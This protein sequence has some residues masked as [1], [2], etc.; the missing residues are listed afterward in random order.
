MKLNRTVL[1][2]ASLVSLTAWS[3]C[4]LPAYSQGNDF[5]KFLQNFSGT[6]TGWSDFDNRRTQID[7][8]IKTNLTNKKINA[9]QAT[10]LQTD[11][12]KI[13]QAA[14][15]IRLN[16]KNPSFT[17][18]LALT[19][20]LNNLYARLQQSVTEAQ[21][22]LP[23][24]TLLRKQLQERLAG[25][26]S[27]GNLSQ[28]DAE[29]VNHDLKHAADIE[30]AFLAAGEGQL[31]P[32]QTQIL[33][34]DLEKTK[35]KLEQQIRLSQSAVPE[36]NSRRTAIEKKILDSTA[37]GKVSVQQ[38][39]ELRAE[40]AR[41]NSMQTTFLSSEGALS[42]S[43]VLALAGDLDKLNERIDVLCRL[44]TTTTTTTTTPSTP[45]T[46]TPST[47]TP[48][49]T[50]PSAT[51]PLLVSATA[52][53]DSKVILL[54]HRIQDNHA[55]GAL[56]TDTAAD[57]RRESELI[58]ALAV[59][60]KSSASGITADHVSK[61]IAQI[62]VVN[63]K[64]DSAIVARRSSDYRGDFGSHG[65]DRRDSD[66]RDDYRRRP[67]TD[68]AEA[69][70]YR[71]RDRN[72]NWNRNSD[73]QPTAQVPVAPAPTSSA[74][75][76]IDLRRRTRELREKISQAALSTKLSSRETSQF[77]AD[78]DEIDHNRIAATDH[79]GI[80]SAEDTVALA[81]D[82]DRLGMRIDQLL[83]ARKSPA[84]TVDQRRAQLLKRI[85]DAQASAKLTKLES[86]L[87][88]REY[89]RVSRIE[90]QL[91]GRKLTLSAAS[92]AKVSAELDKLDKL[93]T[94]EIG[95]RG[96]MTGAYR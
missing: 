7:T 13:G 14:D 37:A 28:A 72:E 74:A 85:S 4:V 81:G 43:R 77:G 67:D 44:A 83:R 25:A 71:N 87:L 49:A 15:Q 92:A 58:D 90:Q 52:D 40:L 23:D 70:D 73:Q 29:E 45:T 18:S 26:I 96:S 53:L 16:G 95:S 5:M 32:K 54:R 59:A 12:S 34:S 20:D 60:Y 84:L 36:L 3:V 8:E 68:R 64:I 47:T 27:A 89:D 91:R 51:T 76:D 19:R 75:A 94:A 56:T 41:I 57:L 79:D 69:P 62:D 22:S 80:V 24:V 46:T 31:T 35:T 65:H 2:A 63:R 48:S 6:L 78:L 86:T 10:A 88:K 93:I 30:A 17:Q 42:G 9:E 38:S 1:T 50:T 82:L 39:A 11:L 33:Y 21:T 66:H 61:L 55:A